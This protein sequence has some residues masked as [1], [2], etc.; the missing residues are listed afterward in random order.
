MMLFDTGAAYRVLGV[1]HADLAGAY[2]AEFRR[3]ARSLVPR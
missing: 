3:T 1:T 2:L